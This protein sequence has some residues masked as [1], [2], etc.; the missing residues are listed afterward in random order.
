MK[1]EARTMYEVGL[2]I[3]GY[4]EKVRE[5]EGFS[6]DDLANYVEVN[7]LTLRNAIYK[8]NWSDM[9]VTI[10]KL[11]NTIPPE[12]CYEYRKSAEMERILK[13]KERRFNHDSNED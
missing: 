10:L 11:K 2:D 8:N 7:S 13:R 1:N 12:L 5:M 3:K 9:L 4:L 6:M